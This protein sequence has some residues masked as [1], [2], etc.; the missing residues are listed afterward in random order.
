MPTESRIWSP[1]SRL[2][3]DRVDSVTIV[4][5]Q[6]AYVYDSA[7]KEYLDGTAGL[8]Y[9]LIGHGREEMAGAVADQIRTLAAFKTHGDYD[10]PP[11]LELSRKL[12]ERL[13]VDDP[14]VFFTT[15]GGDSIE[16]ACKMARGYWRLRNRPDKTLLISRE[17]AYHG[18]NGFGTRVVGISEL[19]SG[20]EDGYPAEQV[21]ANDAAAL[22]AAIEAAGAGRVAAFLA[23][24]VI[25]AGG[26]IPPPPGYFA[27][28]Q[29]ICRTNDVLFICDEIV[30]AFGRLGV[31]SGSELYQIEPDIVTIA[32]GVTSGYIPLGAV[33][34]ARRIWRAFEDEGAMFR[35]GYTYSGHPTACAAALT[36]IGIIEAE[37]LVEHTGRLAPH[38]AR[39]LRRLETSP[40]VTEV[41]AIGLMAGIGL[42]YLPA[43]TRDA[44]LGDLLVRRC[45][46]NGVIV[47]RMFQGDIQI[48]PPL[49]IGERDIKLMVDAIESA[50]SALSELSA[51]SGPDRG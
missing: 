46:D 16:T 20:S 13:P 25:G 33:L 28:V 27:D 1:F 39:E 18:M 29:E 11:A 43:E 32:K 9:T 38:F 3:Q 24:P 41:R 40:L 2:P 50:L 15:G 49:V 7:G 37:G 8:W 22:A 45:R 10:N 5:G 48:T 36:N 35:H 21:P 34:A 26:V 42:D 44:D 6:G 12:A 51:S 47:R 17:G 19:R 23:E 30:T 4:R 14:L 31:W